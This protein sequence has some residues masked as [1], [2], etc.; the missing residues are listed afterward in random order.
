MNDGSA[1]GQVASSLP[2]SAAGLQSQLEALFRAAKSGNSKQFADLVSE[3]QVPDTANW[4]ASTF[5]DETGAKSAVT[6]RISW[7]VYR[8]QIANI[9]HDV[10]TIKNVRV[11]VKEFSTSSATPADTFVHAVL[12]N[13]KSPLVVYTAGAGRDHESEALPGVYVFVQGAFR[14]VNW[15][16]FYDLPNVKPIRVR[17]SGSI[18][19]GQLIHRVNPVISAEARQLH[20][21]QAVLIHTI[22]DRDG[23]VS[24]AEAVSGPVELKQSAVEAVRQWRFKPTV[25]SGDPV[26]MDTTLAVTFSFGR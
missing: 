20:G 14:V 17:V 19:Q 11:Y 2:E 8:E 7:E 21:Q 24:Q 22:I 1:W 15:R 26:E 3:L 4:F 5:G 13:A 25:L 18:A 6:Y 12:Q 10:G 23:N 16:A 9:F